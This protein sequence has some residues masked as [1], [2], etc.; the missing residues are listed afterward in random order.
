[1]V[2]T[3]ITGTER[4][5]IGQERL[6]GLLV[7]P[8]LAKA[9]VIFGDG[10]GA[11]RSSPSSHVAQQLEYS[12]FA[13][14]FLDLLS[15]EEE[16]DR[17]NLFDIDLLASRLTEA[18]G[19]ARG[20]PQLRRFPIG[21]FGASTAGGAAL[22]AAA[23]NPADVRAIVSLGGRP[24][25]A[26]EWL[27]AVKAPTLLLVGSHDPQ[28]LEIN[29]AAM[30]R[31]KCSIELCLVPGAGQSFEEHGR[32]DYVVRQTAQWFERYLNTD[33]PAPIHLPSADYQGAAQIGAGCSITDAASP[34]STI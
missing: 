30:A 13:T 4:I 3:Q 14:L 27:T 17:G 11:S 23:M 15:P 32:L 25:L 5:I 34:R 20:M 12:G 16:A 9:L 1:M 22:A 6:G 31:M 2:A 24:D 28:V 7:V 18:T 33:E 26:R 21:Y 29:H 10:S 19:W 8:P